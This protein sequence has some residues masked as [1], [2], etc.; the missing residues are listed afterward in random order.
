MQS[1]QVD[2]LV[3]GFNSKDGT[4]EYYGVAPFAANNTACGTYEQCLASYVPL[5]LAA[6]A[7]VITS[8]VLEMQY[9]FALLFPFRQCW[10]CS[11]EATTTFLPDYYY[12]V[13]M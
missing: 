2:N 8:P 10:K 1:S 3:V 11:T 9:R 5:Q 6:A 12:C 7:A 13:R 4:T